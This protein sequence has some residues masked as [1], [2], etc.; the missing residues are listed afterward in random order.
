MFGTPTI[1]TDIPYR[2]KR[3]IADYNVSFIKNVLWSIICRITEMSQMLLTYYSQ[4]PLQRW[5]FLSTIS[6]YQD[7]ETKSRSSLKELD[8]NTKLV[9]SMQCTTEQRSFPKL[10]KMWVSELSCKL[11]MRCI[12]LNEMNYKLHNLIVLSFI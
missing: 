9:N 10:E 1:R 3:S 4:I 8:F 5:V 7:Q 11:S 12:T 2:D 6:T